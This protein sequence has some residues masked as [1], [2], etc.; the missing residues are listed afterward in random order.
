VTLVDELEICLTRLGFGPAD[1]ASMAVHAAEAAFLPDSA[2]VGLV[3]RVREGW[4]R[5]AARD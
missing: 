4:R 5:L 2:R 1:V 3:A